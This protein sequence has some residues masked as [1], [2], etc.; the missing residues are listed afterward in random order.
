[1]SILPSLLLLSWFPACWASCHLCCAGFSSRSA[2]TMGAFAE[3]GFCCTWLLPRGGR[4]EVVSV[5][6]NPRNSTISVQGACNFFCSVLP[7]QKFE[8]TDNGSV[9]QPSDRPVLQPCVTAQFHLESKGKYILEAWRWADPKDAKRRE[10]P[11]SI[12]APFFLYVFSPSPEPVLWKL[13]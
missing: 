11:R 4:P 8:A 13:G 7:L 5:G 9:L 3:L 6:L 1:M 10:A 12:L 2:S